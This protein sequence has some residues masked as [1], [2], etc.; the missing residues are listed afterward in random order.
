L[1]RLVQIKPFQEIM[2]MDTWIFRPGQGIQS[3]QLEIN[4]GSSRSGLREK[5]TPLLGPHASHQPDDDDY[6]DST[7]R[8]R[9]D[10]AGSLSSIEMMGGKLQLDGIELVAT[11]FTTL[12]EALSKRRGQEPDWN[13]MHDRAECPDLGLGFASNFHCGGDEEDDG[14]A[15]VLLEPVIKA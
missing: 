2:T 10:S 8:L 12:N 15:W 9:F 1:L 4:F 14:I 3:D 6:V 13:Y 5:L 11:E 7:L